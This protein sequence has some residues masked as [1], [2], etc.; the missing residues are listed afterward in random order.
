[1]RV[2]TKGLMTAVVAMLISLSAV[3]VMAR[4][5]TTKEVPR[6]SK[7]DLKAMLGKPDV[8][9]LDVRVQDQWEVADQKIPGAVHE[10]PAQ[11]ATAWLNKYPKDKPIVLYCA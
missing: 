7:E 5:T 1:M 9:I 4:P 3:G 11:D 6:I 8:T 10:N 2:V